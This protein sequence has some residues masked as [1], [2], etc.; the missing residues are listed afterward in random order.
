[1]VK[2]NAY[3]SIAKYKMNT[4][5]YNGAVAECNKVLAFDAK[6]ELALVNRGIAKCRQ[7]LFDTICGVI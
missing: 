7:D 2:K 4:K 5:D 1:M 6:N 3:I